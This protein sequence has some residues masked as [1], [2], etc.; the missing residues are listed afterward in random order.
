MM[1]ETTAHYGV[2]ATARTD[3]SRAVLT[4]QPDMRLVRAS[5]VVPLLVLTVGAI[6]YSLPIDTAIKVGFSPLIA[7]FILTLVYSVSSYDEL[8]R[9]VYTVTP[10]Y[11]ES[12]T[13]IIEKRIRNIPLSYVRDVTHDQNVIQAMFGVSTITVSTTNGD[14]IVLR[15]VLDGNRKR[16]LIAKQ[17]LSKSPRH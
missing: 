7:V 17:A 15:D 4:D 16:D 14:K 10:E 13:G 8:S 5:F 11:V 12:R 1:A 3:D 2:R 9:A 6:V